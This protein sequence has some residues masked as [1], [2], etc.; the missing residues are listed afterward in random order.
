MIQI[1]NFVFIKKNN[2]RA[3]LACFEKVKNKSMTHII[4]SSRFNK[5]VSLN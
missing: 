4:N 5:L 3:F 1:H 2:V